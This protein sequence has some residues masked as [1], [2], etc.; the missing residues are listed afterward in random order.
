MIPQYEKLTTGLFSF[1]TCEGFGR[2]QRLVTGRVGRPRWNAPHLHFGGGA[3]GKT[4]DTDR[5]RADR[6]CAEGPG[7]GVALLTPLA[8]EL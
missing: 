4:S 1:P 5:D 2:G 3:S 7:L 6:E 8:H